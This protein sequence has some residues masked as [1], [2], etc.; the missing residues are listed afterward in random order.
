MVRNREQAHRDTL[1][2]LRSVGLHKGV[3][4]LERIGPDPSAWSA[5][6]FLAVAKWT[7]KSDPG[8]ARRIFTLL[9]QSVWHAPGYSLADIRNFASGMHFW[10]EHLLPD[11][12]RFDAC[13]ERV[14]AV[15][16][17]ILHPSGRA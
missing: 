3:A 8:G 4:A 1:A 6:D 2:R 11:I 16:D 12:V 7:M 15:H 17:A 13:L 5:E 14:P 10:L 9:R